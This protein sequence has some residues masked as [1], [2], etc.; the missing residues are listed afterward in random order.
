MTTPQTI[1][2]TNI[3]FSDQGGIDEDR[4][5]ADLGEHSNWPGSPAH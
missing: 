1:L 5:L 2:S 4:D 3:I